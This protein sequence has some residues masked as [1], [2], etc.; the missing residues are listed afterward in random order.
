MKDQQEGLLIK[1]EDGQLMTVDEWASTKVKTVAKLEDYRRV[2]DLV[3][4]ARRLG[5]AIVTF[6]PTQTIDVDRDAF[7]AW[8]NKEGIKVL[9]AMRQ[10]REGP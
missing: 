9:K 6:T 2:R 7:E 1:G 10:E 4:E 3:D 8:L 5:F